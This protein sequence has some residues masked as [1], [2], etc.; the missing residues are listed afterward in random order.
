MVWV[1]KSTNFLM[2]LNDNIYPQLCW[3]ELNIFY[4]PI[5]FTCTVYIIYKNIIESKINTTIQYHRLQG[6]V[7]R[8]NNQ[9]LL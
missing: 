8:D 3:I 2:L 9:Q 6:K 4:S 7:C 5:K 1:K